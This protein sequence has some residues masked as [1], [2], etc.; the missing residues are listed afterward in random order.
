MADPNDK[1]KTLIETRGQ[2]GF[3]ILAP[4]HG[5]IHPSGQPY[6]L[7]QD[8]FETIATITPEERRSLFELARTFD[9]MP[10]PQADGPGQQ[11]VSRVADPVMISTLRLPGLTSWSRMDGSWST[12]AAMWA[13]GDGPGRTQ[14]SLRPRTIKAPTSSMCSVQV[15]LLR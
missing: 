14:A 1:V 15:P 7:L 4:S 12:N 5:P 3:I 11:V 9:Q 10:K 8:G 13:T 6:V 2:G